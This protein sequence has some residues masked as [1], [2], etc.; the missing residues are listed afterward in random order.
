MTLLKCVSPIDGAIVAEREALSLDAARAA[1]A[2]AK[3]AQK[4]WAARPLA[5]RIALVRSGV[6]PVPERIP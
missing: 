2:R 3:T 1:V 5:E 6:D 4:A